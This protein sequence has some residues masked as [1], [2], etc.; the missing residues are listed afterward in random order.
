[1]KKENVEAIYPLSPAQQGMLLYLVVTP[2][3]TDA[4]FEQFTCTLRGELDVDA[5]GQAWRQVV[6]RHPALR[7]FFLWEHRDK[8]LQV[9]LRQVELPWQEV[10]L[11]G[12]DDAEQERR[13]EAWLADDRRRGFDLDA[14][15]LLRVG[16]LRIADDVYRCAWSFSH[17]LVDGWSTNLVLQDVFTV[18]FAMRQSV[19]PGLE[20]ARPFSDYIRWQQHQELDQAEAYWRGVLAG[21]SQPITLAIDRR[22]Q[23]PAE[24]QLRF[25]EVQ[26]PVEASVRQ[27]IES[28]ARSQGLTQNVI[29]QGA[30]TLLLGRYGGEEDVITG[31]VVSGRPPEIDGVESIVGL[32]INA[33]PARASIAAGQSLAPWLRELQLQL[34]DQRQYEYCPLE[35]IQ[36]WIGLPRIFEPLLAFQNMPAIADTSAERDLEVT[37]VHLTEETNYPLVLYVIPSQDDILLRVVHD[38]DRFDSAAVSSML[39][40]FQALLGAFAVR[41]E[42]DLGSFSLLSPAQRREVLSLGAGERSATPAEDPVH[43]L[44][45]ERARRNPGAVAV[46]VAG[47]GAELTYEQLDRRSNRLAHHLR[48]L[49]GPRDSSH[50]DLVAVAAER[51]PEMIVA[52]L[53]V[54][55]AGAAYLPLDPA[56]PDERLRFMLEDSAVRLLITQEALRERFTGVETVLSLDGADTPWADES[57]DD[58]GI[59]M[60]PAD[61]AYVIYTS[62]STGK[63][64]GVLIEHGSLSHYSR[65]A[66]DAYG[67]RAADRVLQFASLSFDTSAEE[68]YPCLTRGA[69]LVLRNEEMLASVDDFLRQL[70]IDRVTLL[71]LPTAYWHEIS[72]ELAEEPAPAVPESLRLVIIGGEKALGE[73]LARWR[74]WLA[75]ADREIRL[76]NTYGPTEST[77]VITRCELGSAED[78]ELATDPPIGR[79]IGDTRVVLLDRD[80]EP[81]PRGLPGELY[82][83]GP[84]V[85][86]GYLNRPD[87]TVERFVDDPFA[88]A[89]VSGR[90]Y[91]TGDLA[92][93]RGDGQ[94]EFCGRADDQIKVRG[95][96]I[97]PGEVEAA[98]AEHPAVRDAA[99]VAREDVPGEPRLVAYVVAAAEE[100]SPDRGDLRSHLLRTLP[101]YMVPAAFVTLESLP[102]SPSGKVDRRALPAPE[103]PARRT[104][105]APRNQIEEL[106]AS[107]WSDLLG[108]ERVGID[109]NFFELGGHSLVVGRFTSRLRKALGVTLPML[110]VF[111]HPTVAEVAER[112]SDRLRAAEGGEVADGELPPIERV[113][114]DRPLPLSFPQERVWF[115]QQ[116]SPDSLAYNFQMTLRFL[117]DLEVDVLERALTELVRRHEV[118]HTRFPGVEGMPV[119]V[120]EQPWQVQLPVVDLSGLAEEDREAETERLAFEATQVPFDLARLPMVRWLLLRTGDRDHR[121]NQIEHHFVH[122][123]WSI[124]ILMRE[125]KVLYE[126]YQA[127]QPSPLPDLEVQYADFAVW[128]RQRL[129]GDP[130]ARLLGYW[131]KQL[132]G[133]PS[134]LE[135]PTDRPR[136][137]TPSWRGNNRTFRMPFDLY[138]DVR[139]MSRDHGVTL[140]MGMLAG[141]YT[142]L[143]RYTGEVDLPVGAGVANR[144]GPEVEAIIGMMVNSV[145]MRC[146]LDGDPTF[147]QLMKRVRQVTLGAYAHEDM[148]FEQ[149][150]RELHPQREAN[151]NPLFQVMFSFHDAG[152]PSFD[153]GG[154]EVGYA[155]RNNRSAK[156]DINVIVAP[157]AEQLVGQNAEDE[158]LWAVITWEYSTELFDTE[159]IDRMI[160]HYLALLRSAVENPEQR[161]SALEMLTTGEREQMLSEWTATAT[162]YPREATVHRLFEEW[163]E[164]T[165]EAV[166]LVVAGEAGESREITYRQ[167]DR[168]A[169][170]LARRLRQLGVGPEVPV[171]LCLERSAGLV[172]AELAVLKAGGAYVPYDPA[173]P[174]RRLRLLFDDSAVSVLVTT[175]ELLPQLPDALPP[176][177]VCLDRDREMLDGLDGEPIESGEEAE[178]APEQLAYVMYTSGSTGRPKGVSVCHRSVVRLVRDTDYARFGVDEVFLQFAPAS[179]DASTLEVW[180]PLLNGGR[181]VIAPPGRLSLEELAAV[182]GE[183]GV[184]TAWL[185][186]GLFHQMVEGGHLAQLSDLRQLLAGGDALAAARVRQALA[187][188]PGTTVINGY[189]PTENT[190]F[191]CCHPMTDAAE[192]DD[193]VSIGKPI[194]NTSVYVAGDDLRPVPVGVPGELLAAGDGLARGY[195]RRP[196][197]TA[198]LFVPNPVAETPGERLYRTGDLVRYASDGRLE[199]L[200]RNDFQVKIRGFRIEPGEIDAVLRGHDRIGECAVVAREDSP[201]DKRLVAYVVTADGQGDGDGLETDEELRAY[202]VQRF[203]DYMIPAA[204]VPLDRLPLTAN[205]KLDRRALPVPDYARRAEDAWVAPRTPLEETLSGVW[206]EVLSVERAGA[207]DDF[208]ELGGHS[209]L[210][211]QVISRMRRDHGIEVS[212][213]QLFE[214]PI[215]GDLALVLSSDAGT[216][217]RSIVAA[218]GDEPATDEILS[219]ADSMSDGELDALLQTM[220]SGGDHG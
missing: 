45:A 161:I 56:Y 33:L 206:R 213:A 86:R 17:L 77:I 134:A 142:L 95:F 168:R 217:A 207:S 150:V 179:F 4:F 48:R 169:N 194:R 172:V 100:P 185:T 74:D 14:A 216:A 66:A 123:G 178:A 129:T 215:L 171:G 43:R 155:T 68:I 190:T 186:A 3:A 90:L 30:W 137:K 16:L 157:R 133:M 10:D 128:Q 136:P 116:L 80:L 55:K 148:P 182:T 69:T 200:G 158:E 23:L 193:S 130:M 34:V 164:R 144:R 147:H 29:F 163:A 53:G 88:P 154:L 81:V 76:F 218:A 39:D 89:G 124:S 132:Q 2:E 220:L 99:V 104:Y 91:R 204:F 98:L 13:L 152:M 92:R 108:A 127:G 7:S 176:S 153:F 60:M 105:A 18:Y 110:S 115:L 83:G 151:R 12:L 199:F 107:L 109:D 46:A 27:G 101:D 25:A 75:A 78:A 58:P 212:L 165:S 44:F 49:L 181:L 22:A 21:F 82:V 166:A 94:L 167:L 173:Y 31:S 84:G 51:S 67:A 211:T 208:F 40:H 1:M 159:T 62:G 122:D 97:E 184:T 175:E 191:T 209:L 117:G 15:P 11:R 183:Y 146:G 177:V 131:R 5:L 41:P 113:P 103:A 114:R 73:R 125:L 160:H 9:V 140:Y 210:A 143:H 65:D 38:A 145:V 202:L 87:L 139:A 121:L 174:E 93:F 214:T 197:L 135:L 64:K 188:L 112:V 72:A 20:A 102:L 79:P 195:Y 126:A 61:L 35:Q 189:G 24:R 196:A 180:G 111:E 52:L 141:F 37:D 106:V 8:P 201:G 54:L 42:D 203:P 118:F 47:G 162:D 156:T 138:Q 6:A 28:L 26:V 119:Q 205:G 63:P 50:D 170:R 219:G 198:E 32:F 120:V 187:E 149:L 71:N 57:A 192:V 59:E 85:A 36:R 70:D 19:E 96:R